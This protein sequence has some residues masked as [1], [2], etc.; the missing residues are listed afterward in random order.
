M[1]WLHRIDGWLDMVWQAFWCWFFNLRRAL[2]KRAFSDYPVIVLS[3]EILERAPSA[4]WYYTLLPTYRPSLSLEALDDALHRIAGDPDTKGV[5]FQVKGAAL[6]LA[7]AQSLAASF[8]RFRDW[9]QTY[10]GISHGVGAKQIFFHFEQFTTATYVAACAADKIAMTPLTEWDLTGLFTAPI[11]WKDS[12]ARLGLRFDVVR[13]A[14]WKTAADTLVFNGLTDAARDQF[15]W[16]YDSIYASIVDAIATG[17]DLPAETVRALI[18]RAPLPAQAALEAG[19][20]DHVVYE[21]ELSVLLGTPGRNYP[22][23]PY[24]QIRKLLFR[25]P[26]PNSFQQIGVI[27]LQ[28]AIMP[29]ES[30]SFPLPLPLLGDETIGSTTAQQL[31][32]QARKDD[33]LAAI[34][35]HVDSPGGSALASDL[36]W[37]ELALLQE[38][39]PLIVYMGDVAASGGYYV[40]APAHKIVAQRASITGSI[41][42]IMAKLITTGAL[43]KVDAHRES[44]QRGKHADIYSD[45]APWENGLRANV[46]ESLDFV[47]GEFKRRV[48]EGRHLEIDALD[49]LAGGRVWTGE[50]AFERGLVDELGDFQAAVALA[51][52]AAGLPTDGSIR[53]TPV[54]EPRRRLMAEPAEAARDALGLGRVESAAQLADF[55]L[56]GELLRLAAHESIWLLAPALPK[57]R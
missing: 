34:V 2:F 54:E 5:I 44:I 8:A 13:A 40:A 42:V 26:R 7:Q 24:R 38:E 41:G 49:D 16:L 53:V 15:N 27:S 3:G 18:D 32:R 4:P 20:I 30:R 52:T 45:M 55:V 43:E 36:I 46:E 51:C 12:L 29:G 10:N 14:P 23:K 39:K 21:D 1:E 31:I 33:S 37:R 48:A 9:D 25:R 19:L 28:G 11:F 50:Q 17:R 35:L 56:G 57:T 22:P 6:S 47:Y